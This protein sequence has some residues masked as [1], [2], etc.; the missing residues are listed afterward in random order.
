MFEAVTRENLA[1]PSR[2]GA[3]AVVSVGLHGLALA[4]ALFFGARELPRPPDRIS[5]EIWPHAPPRG[6]TGA[7]LKPA[8]RRGT[9]QPTE[10]KPVATTP[11]RR[12]APV[13]SDVPQPM[14]PTVQDIAVTTAT[15]DQPAGTPDGVADGSPEGVG[16]GIP[17]GGDGAGPG[18]METVLYRQAGMTKPTFLGGE[19]ILYPRAALDA[20][21]DDKVLARCVL[22]IEGTLRECRI[23]KGS[24]LLHHAVLNALPTYR[25]T[26]VTYE[27]RP[28]SIY[29]DLPLRVRAE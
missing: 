8:A 12:R 18:N 10:Q 4:A 21:V 20:N 24:P 14:A 25:F 13:P 16:N 29:Y 3:G 27:G 15:S 5:V 17:P 11:R 1:T 26:P 9:S 22:T 7:D 6:G 19:P 2:L 23:L 28:V